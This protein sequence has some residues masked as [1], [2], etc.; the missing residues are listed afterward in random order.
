MVVFHNLNTKVGLEIDKI[1]QDWDKDK[2]FE[3]KL[4]KINLLL[5]KY[6]DEGELYFLA[7][8]CYQNMKNLEKALEWYELS[9]K[10]GYKENPLW[11]YRGYVYLY[12]SRFDEAFEDFNRVNKTSKYFDDAVRLIDVLKAVVK[13]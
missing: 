6:S 10:K 8:S 13:N 4:D 11:Y 9:E 1:K 2:N 7:G 12:L 5:K 3:K